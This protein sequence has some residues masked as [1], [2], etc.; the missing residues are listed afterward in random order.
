VRL[1]AVLLLGLAAATAHAAQPAPDL[2]IYAY[3]SFAAKGGLGP[4]IVPLFEK[5][6]LCHVSVLPSGDGGQLLNRVQLDAEA[7]RKGAHI[8]VGLDQSIWDRAK[9]WTEPWGEWKPKRL[10]KVSPAHR[11]EAGFVP[12]D[13]GI[14]AFMADETALAKKHLAEPRSLKDLLATELKR[15]ILLE[16]PRT[17]TPG[18]AFLLFT[19]QILGEGAVWKWWD[20]FRTQWLTL[21]PGWDQA[22]GLFLKGEAPLVWSYVTSQAYHIEHGEPSRYR[23]ILFSGGN[24]VQIEGAAIVKGAL[25][26]PRER[27]LAHAFLEFLLSPD[28]QTRIPLKNWMYPVVNGTKLPSSFKKLP[29]VETTISFRASESIVS[30]ILK[31]WGSVIRGGKP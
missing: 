12:F 20:A 19:H 2:V 10:D 31:S 11:V 3:D 30:G 6:C 28:V 8:L 1:L 14:F 22:Y 24:P 25:G 23:A 26:T 5:S 16:D 7:K 15:Q 18:L 4:E 29:V 13:Y 17:S 21:S 27:E 9:P